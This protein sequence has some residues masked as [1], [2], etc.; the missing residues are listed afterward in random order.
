MKHSK[1][2]IFLLPIDNHNF[3]KEKNEEIDTSLKKEKIILDN[4][5]TSTDSDSHKSKND[6]ENKSKFPN[7]K[8]AYS[9]S[10]FTNKNL[11]QNFNSTKKPQFDES[12]KDEKIQNFFQISQKNFHIPNFLFE[13]FETSQSAG[14]L[15]SYLDIKS[16][17]SDFQENLIDVGKKNKENQNNQGE[18]TI[19]IKENKDLII[20]GEE[21]NCQKNGKNKI[22]EF[23][24]DDWK[25]N[26]KTYSNTKFKFYKK[27]IFK[28]LSKNKSF[29]KLKINMNLINNT[30]YSSTNNNHN[31]DNSKKPVTY[32]AEMDNFTRNFYDFLNINS[33]NVNINQV[34]NFK[35]QNFAN[36]VYSNNT[37]N[38]RNFS[39]NLGNFQGANL[40]N[41]EINYS[42]NNNNNNFG[43]FNLRDN[44]P[45]IYSENKQSFSYN[46]LN[47]VDNNN[48]FQGQGNRNLN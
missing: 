10:N 9:I 41:S 17:I 16:T 43:N 28:R 8:S 13:E 29:T 37:L 20:F 36:S 15:N 45:R 23:F 46:Y 25:N 6:F 7:F 4:F 47:S 32:K 34:R 14:N 33:Y 22:S 30:R 40:V 3:H 19:K 5:N 24:A 27:K 48:Y 12:Q 2:S 26:Y 11:S 44:R 31:T 18:N 35:Y 38:G 42:G 39:G 1:N 21:N